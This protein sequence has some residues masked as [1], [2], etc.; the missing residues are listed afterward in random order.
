MWIHT[1][2]S[3]RAKWI[4]TGIVGFC[5]LIGGI[6]NA[7]TPQRIPAQVGPAP[8]TQPTTAPLPTEP[9]KPTPTPKPVEKFKLDI[10][11]LVVKKVDGKYRYF[12]NILNHQGKSFEGSVMIRLYSE[13]AIMGEET[14]TTKKPIE[15]NLG[16]TVYFDSSMA[17]KSRNG[18]G[19]DRFVYTINIDNSEVNSGEGK[20]A[21]EYEDLDSYK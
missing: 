3:K 15:P 13:K 21:T 11:S 16:E 10:S 19:V 12:F 17:P 4:V 7:A 6:V 5:F 2:W 20:I 14:F 8:T 1:G 9:P 18:Y